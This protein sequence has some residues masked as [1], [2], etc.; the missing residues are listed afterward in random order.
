MTI[1]DG[2]NKGDWIIVDGRGRNAHTF[3]INGT[4]IF[5]LVLSRD[6]NYRTPTKCHIICNSIIMQ[7]NKEVKMERRMAMKLDVVVKFNALLVLASVAR[8]RLFSTYL[9]TY[10]YLTYFCLP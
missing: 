5:L 2:F 1:R 6:Y 7:Q 3:S 9:L 4:G 8:H 10:Y